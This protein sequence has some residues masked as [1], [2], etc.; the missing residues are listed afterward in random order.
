M[1]FSCRHIFRIYV[2]FVI[3]ICNF[4]WQQSRDRQHVCA[5]WMYDWQTDLVFFLDTKFMARFFLVGNSEK[6]V[7]QWINGQMWRSLHAHICAVMLEIGPTTTATLK[8]ERSPCVKYKIWI[9]NCHQTVSHVSVRNGPR[10]K[11][12]K[13]LNWN[14]GVSY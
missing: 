5:F 14:Q 11:E 13:M 10:L 7:A 1:V 9:I 12:F 2:T 4:L 8:H 6:I 3:K